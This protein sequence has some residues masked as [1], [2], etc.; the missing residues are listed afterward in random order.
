M[1]GMMAIIKKTFVVQVPT[2]PNFIKVGNGDTVSI[3]DFSNKELRAIGSEWTSKLLKTANEKR[4]AR[5]E[6][7]T[8]KGAQELNVVAGAERG[9]A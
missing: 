8:P 9:N 4:K 3:A 1:E 5:N 2:V 7:P 6:E